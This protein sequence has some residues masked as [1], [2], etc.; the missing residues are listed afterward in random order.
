MLVSLVLIL[1]GTASYIA[2]RY[3]KWN[4]TGFPIRG[5]DISHHNGHVEWAKV[6]TGFTFVIMKATQGNAFKDPR[7]DSN[8][9]E[10]KKKGL[11]RGA[12]HYFHPGIP[13]AQQFK[14]FQS[15]VRLEKGDLP[16]MLDVEN[17]MCDMNEVG[18]WMQMAERHYGMKPVL[19]STYGFFKLLIANKIPACRL[20]LYSDE[21][22]GFVPS[23]DNY[24][25]IIWQHSHRG[26]I[27]GFRGPVDLN[28]FL[29]DQFA[30]EGLLKN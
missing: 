3:A 15:N 23:V 30:F 9:N 5:I 11:V 7:F 1:A 26:D 6:D 24:D 12:Y 22:H 14:H 29:G 25:C 21:K 19:Y 8:W 27:R 10:A 17:K 16:P 13:A 18:K 4:K 2:I 28:R 20:W